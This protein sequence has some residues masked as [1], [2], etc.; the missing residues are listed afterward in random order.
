MEPLALREFKAFKA[1]LELLELMVFKDQL[2]LRVLLETM[3][4]QA[5]L[6]LRALPEPLELEILEQLAQPDYLA[7]KALLEFKALLELQE[8]VKLVRLVQRDLMELLEFKAMRERLVL[9]GHLEAKEQRVLLVLRELQALLALE[10]L[11]LQ[12]LLARQV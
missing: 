4:R 6:E 7:A 11:V 3:E 8:L 2:E 5:R 10:I 9:L 12:G 1:A